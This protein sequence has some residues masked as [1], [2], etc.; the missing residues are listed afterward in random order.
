MNINPK[1]VDLYHLNAN[2]AHGGDGADFH[3]AYAWGIRGVI[4]KA[5]QTT[6]DSLYAVRR[7]KALAAGLLWG[8]YHFNTGEP[9]ARQVEH[10]LDV[11]K[12]DRNTVLALDWEDENGHRRMHLAQ[13]RQFMELVDAALE[14]VGQKPDSC[15]LYSGNVVKEEI[16]H[17][18][19]ETRAFFGAHRLWLAQYAAAPTMTDYNHHPLPW[20]K[21]WLWQYTGD[22]V[23]P[24]PRNVPGIGSQVD[25][26]SFAGSDEEL[27]AQWSA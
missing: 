25:I 13:A 27:K 10:F 18:D 15:V 3:A 9:V 24:T 26:N 5:S 6:A 17:A 20:Q 1:V 4:H 19:E 7:P 8:G 22:G 21:P 14:K 12:P 11:A 16:A 2:N 23:G